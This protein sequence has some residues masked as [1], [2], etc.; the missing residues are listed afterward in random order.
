MSRH[1]HCLKTFVQVVS[2]LVY[3]GFN[4]ERLPRGRLLAHN[5]AVRD[6]YTA[7]GIL[8]DARKVC[9]FTHISR[10][11]RFGPLIIRR[12]RRWMRR[13]LS[14]SRT[15]QCLRPKPFVAFTGCSCV[16]AGSST[17]TRGTGTSL[18]TPTSARRARRLART[19]LLRCGSNM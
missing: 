8:Q 1:E 2:E 16:I 11:C 6:P 19:L 12:N 5:S 15:L 10:S 13:W 4:D 17:W 18:I 9:S 7:I 14:S 3:F